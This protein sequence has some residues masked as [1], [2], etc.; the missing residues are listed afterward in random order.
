MKL[1]TGIR[2]VESVGMC[3]PVPDLLQPN[4][5]SPYSRSVTGRASQRG[6]EVRDSISVKRF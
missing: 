2:M 5:M 6:W 4:Q 1:C 3:L